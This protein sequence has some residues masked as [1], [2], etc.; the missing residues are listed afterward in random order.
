MAENNEAI[1]AL[2]QKVRE[3][4]IVIDVLKD[5]VAQLRVD[6]QHDIEWDYRAILDE[7][8]DLRR[9]ATKP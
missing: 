1:E 5:E 9:R 6:L 7:L 4:D 8:R 2:T 3:L